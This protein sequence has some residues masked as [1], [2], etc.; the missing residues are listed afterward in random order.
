MTD[1]AAVTQR[2]IAVSRSY[3]GVAGDV[4]N[5][6]QLLRTG[7]A[8]TDA[9]LDAVRD[10]SA[11]IRGS[12][13]DM[14]VTLDDVLA[15][16]LDGPLGLIENATTNLKKA[17]ALIAQVT[18]IVE[19]SIEVVGAAAAVALFIAAPTVAAAGVAV[20]AIGTAASGFAS[21]H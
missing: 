19:A 11:K 21:G 1:V 8:I 18:A 20:A 16:Q 2:V 3:R 17:V 13:E 12:A 9:Q 7:G 6:A 15:A 4:L 10:A 5:Q 14:L